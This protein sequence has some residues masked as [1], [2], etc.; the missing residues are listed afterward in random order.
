M[1]LEMKKFKMKGYVKAVAITTFV[2]LCFMLLICLTSQNETELN[3]LSFIEVIDM[4]DSLVRAV[5]VVFAG[6]LLA[7]Y[8]IDEYKNKTITILFMYPINRKKIMLAKLLLVGIT[9]FFTMLLSNLIL[10]SILYIFATFT[11]TITNAIEIHQLLIKAINVIIID[12]GLT[13]MSLISLYFGMRG[14]S[15]KAT[16]V[17][18]IILVSIVG[19]NW[20]EAFSLV[21]IIYVPIILGIIGI[22]IAYM[23]IRN[24]DNVDV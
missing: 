6:T 9:I 22:A 1:K 14:K 2:L 13:G 24:V 10:S 17:T 7:K 5:Y 23:A 21:T 19:S 11:G 3:F 12:L 15:V 16:I 18:S 20:G 8:I 4:V